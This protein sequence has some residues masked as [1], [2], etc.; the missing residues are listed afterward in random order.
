M[1]ACPP[2]TRMRSVRSPATGG[3][4]RNVTRI[5]GLALVDAPQGW[6]RGRPR[7]GL[8]A[9]GKTRRVGTRASDSDQRHRGGTPGRPGVEPASADAAATFSFGRVSSHNRMSAPG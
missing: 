8:P 4:T 1:Q 9:R 3:S 6:H 2:M 7:S 5:E